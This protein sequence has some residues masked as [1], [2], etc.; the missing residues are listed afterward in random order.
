MGGVDEV[1]LGKAVAFCEALPVSQEELRRSKWSVNKAE[2]VDTLK[3][4]PEGDKTKEL[5]EHRENAGGAARWA[6]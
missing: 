5:Q 3:N 4:T 2:R 6:R 1:I